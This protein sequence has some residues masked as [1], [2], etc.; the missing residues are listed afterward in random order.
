MCES[1]LKDFSGKNKKDVFI[2]VSAIKEGIPERLFLASK[3]PFLIGVEINKCI[4]LLTQNLGLAKGSAEWAVL[5]W[6]HALTLEFEKEINDLETVQNEELTKTM[7]QDE[8]DQEDIKDI[9]K[10]QRSNL[11]Y[12]DKNIGLSNGQK[13]IILFLLAL[14][15]LVIITSKLGADEINGTQYSSEGTNSEIDDLEK[16]TEDA[17]V[18]QNNTGYMKEEDWIESFEEEYILPRSNEEYLS[19]SDISW[20]ESSNDASLLRLAVN[21]IYARHGLAFDNFNNQEYFKSKSWYSPD[22]SIESG[23]EAHNYLSEI[24]KANVK[25]LL[26]IEKKIQDSQD[27]SEAYDQNQNIEEVIYYRVIAGSFKVKDN[28][29]DQVKNLNSYGFNAS[30]IGPNTLDSVKGAEG[31]YCVLTDSFA[32]LENAKAQ[33]KKLESSGFEAVISEYRK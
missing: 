1:Y 6:A 11:K 3:N 12:D 15:L 18:D 29:K 19:D 17:D 4:D 30:I 33:V 32:S 27:E 2:L 22:Y 9:D 26:S 14:I 13:F 31:L 5:N 21:E 20:L 23:E 8:F 7:V 28:A 16:N 10:S 25:K 24:E